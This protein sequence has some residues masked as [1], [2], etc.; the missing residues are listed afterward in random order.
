MFAQAAN[1]LPA[2]CFLK[3]SKRRKSPSMRLVLKGGW[4]ITSKPWCHNQSQVHLAVKKQDFIFLD[5]WLATTLKWM[6]T[7]SC[8]FLSTDTWQQCLLHHYKKFGGMVGQMLQC[9]H[10]RMYINTFHGSCHRQQDVEQVTIHNFYRIKYYEHFT[11]QYFNH[12][13]HKQER[14]CVYNITFRHG[15]AT[16]VAAEKQ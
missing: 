15:C 13:T 12:L 3:G 6:L 8:Y 1:Y 10:I 7:W 11:K 5:P 14:L 9:Q 2:R 16:I 4:P